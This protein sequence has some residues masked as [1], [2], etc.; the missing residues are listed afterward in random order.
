M[1]GFKGKP[2]SREHWRRETRMRELRR[3]GS[4][5]R[6]WVK[7]WARTRRRRWWTRAPRSSGPPASSRSGR[8][9]MMRRRTKMTT[10]T[11]R[12]RKRALLRTTLST[13]WDSDGCMKYASHY[14]LCNL[15]LWHMHCIE[16]HSLA[17]RMYILHIPKFMHKVSLLFD[18]HLSSI[19]FHLP[20][21]VFL[22][23]LTCLWSKIT[24]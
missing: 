11:R 6:Q 22:K 17:Y 16:I 8:A 5:P 23:I 2:T 20:E 7:W 15:Y 9:V 14:L 1:L 12:R 3:K 18:N 10:L 19:S 4:L 21:W 24:S 13:C